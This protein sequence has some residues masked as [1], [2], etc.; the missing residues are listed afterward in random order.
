MTDKTE[1]EKATVTVVE[2]EVDLAE[3]YE[4]W[5]TDHY[6]VRVTT[7]GEEALDCIDDDVDVVL[8]D[9]RMPG[10]SGD[11]VLSRLRDRG[12]DGWVVMVTAVEPDFDIIELG[13]DDYVRKPLTKDDLVTTVERMLERDRYTTD[14]REFAR[15]TAKRAALTT[16]HSDEELQRN[17]AYQQLEDRW[18][19]LADDLEASVADFD[20]AD[21]EGLFRRL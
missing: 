19:T 9:R 13:F 7:S 20:D 6:D 3:L 4:V 17:D 8:L 2:D 1:S 14:L 21:F 16:S 18:Q 12:F 11:E 10:L 5:L 15:L